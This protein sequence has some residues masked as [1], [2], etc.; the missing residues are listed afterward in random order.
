MAGGSKE[1]DDVYDTFLGMLSQPPSSFH[2]AGFTDL[3][4]GWTQAREYRLIGVMDLLWPGLVSFIISSFYSPH[5]SLILTS[6]TWW[7]MMKKYLEM[8]AHYGKECLHE[9]CLWYRAESYWWSSAGTLGSKHRYFGCILVQLTSLL[10][11]VVIT[12]TP[13]LITSCQ[14]PP[15]CFQ[16]CTVQGNYSRTWHEMMQSVA[17]NLPLCLL[18]LLALTDPGAGMLDFF[19]PF[20]RLLAWSEVCSGHV[21]SLCDRRPGAG[22]SACAGHICADAKFPSDDV[23]FLDGFSRI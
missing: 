15:E 22:S 12:W 8:M 17:L 20:C 18:R 14:T 7:M 3:V 4:G 23:C 21:L 5:P 11:Q 1:R 10:K 2:W 16:C 13:P 9:K 6:A 19:C